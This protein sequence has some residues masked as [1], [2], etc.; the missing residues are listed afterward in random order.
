MN[1]PSEIA[2]FLDEQYGED[3]EILQELIESLAEVREAYADQIQKAFESGNRKTMAEAC[4]EIKG[5]VSN[6]G[7]T[8]CWRLVLTCE[9]ASKTDDT[10]IPWERS[11]FLEVYNDMLS[12]A[13]QYLNN[14]AS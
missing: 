5:V 3:T 13:T 4:H 1:Q 9:K 11:H 6:L 14:M 12:S 2:N 8:D 10:R 7:E